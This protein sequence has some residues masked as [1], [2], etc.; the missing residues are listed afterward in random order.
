MK[1]LILFLFIS[2]SFSFAQEK[3]IT[4]YLKRIESGD[5]EKVQREIEILKLKTP[6]DPSIIFLEAVLT[7]NG[8]ESTKLYEK[9][10]VQHPRSRYADASA[11][12]LFSY[13][14]IVSDFDKSIK[15]YNILKNN[16]PNS[17]Y[18]KTAAGF[19]PLLN[20]KKTTYNSVKGDYNIQCGAFVNEANALNLKNTL[21][22]GGYEV[23][24]VNKN[25]G[26]VLFF[27]VNVGSF[28]K[29][30]Q[31]EPML[32]KLQNDFNV[33]GKIVPKD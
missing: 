27:V 15:Y 23:S 10:L 2:F 3:D 21:L 9:I 5:A 7:D 14:Y 6:N 13:N 16:Y 11:Y 22:Q 17:S 33:S 4:G 29:R 8:M 19:Y 32:K 31:A 12:R 24:I 26:G 28:E 18:T 25:I 1:S 20:K 30:E